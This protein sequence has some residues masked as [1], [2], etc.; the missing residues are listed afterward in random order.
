MPTTRNSNKAGTPKRYPVFPTTILTK[1]KMEPT[2]KMFSAVKIIDYT[3]KSYINI[4]LVFT[5]RSYTLFKT[6]KS[7]VWMYFSRKR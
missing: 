3:N 1:S 5:V 2:S 4:K 7:P 6:N